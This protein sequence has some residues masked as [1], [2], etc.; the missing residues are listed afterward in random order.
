MKPESIRYLEENIDS[1]LILVIFRQGVGGGKQKQ[2]RETKAKINKW[3]YIKLNV[4][5]SKENFD[6]SLSNFFLDQS[7]KAKEIKAK[8]NKWDLI[9][10]K[11]F[12]TAKKPLAKWR[13]VTEWGRI[14]AMMW[15][16]RSQYPTYIN[17]SYN[18]KLNIKKKK[19]N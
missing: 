5:H 1:T 8:I 2:S 18:I 17:S 10:L 13:Q 11:S 3:D 19:P 16:I 6:L 12:C 14:F 15:L 9:K 4:L 7:P